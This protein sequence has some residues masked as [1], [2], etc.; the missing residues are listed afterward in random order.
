MRA[1]YYTNSGYARL[2]FVDHSHADSADSVTELS[3]E[4]SAELLVINT[5]ETF[6][7]K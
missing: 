6:G 2:P 5:T 1:N 3:D 7:S 4:S